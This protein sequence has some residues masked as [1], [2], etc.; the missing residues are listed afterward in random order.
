MIRINGERVLVGN[1]SVL[2]DN[3]GET[4]KL[5]FYLSF[6]KLHANFADLRR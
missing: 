3:D 2:V 4:T 6:F 5:Y 1:H